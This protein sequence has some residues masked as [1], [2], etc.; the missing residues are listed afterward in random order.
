MAIHGL[1]HCTFRVERALMERMRA[2]YETAVG[3]VSGP[4]PPFSFAGY[5]LY[6]G[7][8]DVLHLAEERDEDRRRAG[9]DLTFDHIALTT[10]DWPSHRARLAQHGVPYR[11]SQVPGTRIRQISFHDP[12]GNGI[13]LIF[14]FGDD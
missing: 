4:R 9:S 6:A 13:E 2:F 10:T 11:E 7:E 8:R 14:P 5:W 12:A 1:A 3:L